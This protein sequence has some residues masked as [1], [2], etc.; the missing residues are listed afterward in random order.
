MSDPTVI[1]DVGRTLELLLENSPAALVVSLNS[2]QLVT[3]GATASLNLYL[4]QI[5][6]NPHS[7]NHPPLHPHPGVEQR[8]PLSLDLYYMLTPYIKSDDNNT[9]EHLILGDAMQVLYDNS[10]ITDPDLQ[11]SL[12]GVNAHIRLTLCRMNLEEQTRI[13]NA[14]QMSYRLSVCY[15]AR[16]ALVDSRNVRPVHRVGVQEVRYGER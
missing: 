13:W 4:Y 7:K 11:G 12:S 6:E 14:L 15:Q 5:M 16:I 8:A 10:I 1:S 3:P 9:A 2:P